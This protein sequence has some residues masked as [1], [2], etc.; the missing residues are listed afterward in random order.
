MND[1]VGSLYRYFLYGYDYQFEYDANTYELCNN[2]IGNR[3]VSTLTNILAVM[4]KKRKMS[5]FRVS[6]EVDTAHEVMRFLIEY[7]KV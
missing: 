7:R 3:S 1:I 5:G 2:R 4:H 6:T